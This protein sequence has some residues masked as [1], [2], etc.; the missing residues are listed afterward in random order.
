MFA[1]LGA[2]TNSTDQLFLRQESG[3]LILQENGFR[4]A[5]DPVP[6]SRS[7]LLKEDGF[8]LKREDGGGLF[9][10]PY[11][12]PQIG[13]NWEVSLPSPEFN[14]IFPAE[15][16][17]NLVWT[18]VVYGGGTWVALGQASSSF[19]AHTRVIMY[20]STDG[21]TW[22]YVD[23]AGFT[24]VDGH[25]PIN[26]A[27]YVPSTPDGPVWFL[28]GNNGLYNIWDGVSPIDPFQTAFLSSGG[29]VPAAFDI[30]SVAYFN[31]QFVLTG[32]SSSVWVL[33]RTYAFHYGS[34]AYTL[35]SPG[36]TDRVAVVAVGS[37]LLFVSVSSQYSIPGYAK[38]V[39]WKT[40][41]I[42]GV[43]IPYLTQ[44]DYVE[45]AARPTIFMEGTTMWICGGA[46][47][48]KS[49]DLTSFTTGFTT[50]P[51]LSYLRAFCIAGVSRVISFGGATFATSST[52][53]SFTYRLSSAVT[54]LS[55]LATD[56]RK[57][58]GVSGT[59]I[60]SAL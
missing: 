50:G 26:V 12:L 30:K 4:L 45:D 34:N 15:V 46:K 6:L 19:Y 59:S 57:I 11:V 36:V 2:G 49:T 38:I 41:S 18:N 14:P 7:R 13:L 22:S 33:S 54:A 52:E 10:D 3:G 35:A 37:S 20:K 40:T 25:L 53:S 9:L 47:L 28:G 17:T 44:L 16:F 1:L 27:F 31:S 24:Y 5:L 32:D 21:V 29:F 23:T 60:V 48:Y 43:G 42:T 55:A 8:A 58:L 39:L 56:G 51:A